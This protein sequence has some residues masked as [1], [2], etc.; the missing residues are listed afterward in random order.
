MG[1]ALQSNIQKAKGSS[2]TLGWRELLHIPNR[3]KKKKIILRIPFSSH[4]HLSCSLQSHPKGTKRGVQRE[5]FNMQQ[6][7]QC[8]MIPCGF[9]PCDPTPRQPPA[10]KTFLFVTL[11]VKSG[12]NWSDAS[13]EG[14]EQ[15]SQMKPGNFHFLCKVCSQSYVS[16]GEQDKAML[17]AEIH[18]NKL[19]GEAGQRARVFI[20]E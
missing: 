4:V 9:V 12:V 5:Q 14:E 18:G 13:R 19:R 11:A 3:R 16:L 10:C 1:S 6:S 8:L 7:W 20:Q 2:L 17:M 15:R